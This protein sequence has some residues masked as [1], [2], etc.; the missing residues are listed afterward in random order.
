MFE[1]VRYIL[2]TENCPA[3]IQQ[4]Y[5]ITSASITTQ[6]IKYN[7]YNTRTTQVLKTSTTQVNNASTK[8][9]VQQNE[10]KQI[11]QKN[12]CKT[13]TTTQI[14]QHRY[15]TVLKTGKHK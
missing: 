15:N 12:K 4:K 13:I 7:C 8:T 3:S 6:E 9:R 2:Y 14:I 5:Y 10:T 11:L 1:W